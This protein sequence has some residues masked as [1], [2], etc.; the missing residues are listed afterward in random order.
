MIV[1]GLFLKFKKINPLSLFQ[2]LMETLEC[3]SKLWKCPIF[4]SRGREVGRM[5]WAGQQEHEMLS[6]LGQGLR[7]AQT[8]PGP[9]LV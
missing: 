1:E 8:V 5:S 6:C 9:Q 3:V 2:A 4:D 7:T